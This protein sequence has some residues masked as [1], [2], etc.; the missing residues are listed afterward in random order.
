MPLHPETCA[1]C[2]GALALTQHA[3]ETKLP[4]PEAIRNALLLG[5]VVGELGP[6]LETLTCEE[7]KALLEATREKLL[8]PS[9]KNA[10]PQARR[11]G[12]GPLPRDPRDPA[13]QTGK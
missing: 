13:Q 12:S 7:C 4:P 8:T 2:S 3:F 10:E 1:H 9:E 5:V 11:H 6:V